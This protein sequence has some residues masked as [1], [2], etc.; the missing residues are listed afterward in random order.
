MLP[1]I[2]SNVFISTQAHEESQTV[3]KCYPIGEI[4]FIA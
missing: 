2:W 3:S 1:L 4:G